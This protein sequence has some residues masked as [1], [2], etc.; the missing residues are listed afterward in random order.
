VLS[1]PFLKRQVILQMRTGK[2]LKLRI[3]SYYD[4]AT[5]NEVFVREE[6]STRFFS[7]NSSIEKFYQECLVSNRKPLVLDL[8]ANIGVAAAYYS[9]LYPEAILIS[10]EPS[11]RNFT[12]LTSNTL[13][14]GNVKILNQAIGPMSGSQDLYDPGLGNNAYRTF[15]ESKQRVGEVEVSCVN[16]LLASSPESIP[17]IVKIDIEGFESEL[18]SKNLDW[19]D[20]FKVIAIEIH[21]WMLPGQAVSSNFFRVIG[22]K[23]RDLVFRG[24]N[25]FSIRND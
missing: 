21:D 10:V 18:F 14:L 19:V 25:I 11:S 6:Y 15:G 4:W 24:E 20:K 12:L 9:N 7:I 8:G 22:G 16:D 2:L 13:D 1:P 23:N 3:G 17:F 5:I